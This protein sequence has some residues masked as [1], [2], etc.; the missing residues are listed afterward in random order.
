MSVDGH[1]DHADLPDTP[2]EH[3][4]IEIEGDLL[5]TGD[6]DGER[7][8]VAAEYVRRY[9]TEILDRADLTPLVSAL[10]NSGP[11][12]LLCVERGP[13]ACRRSLIALRLTE[14]HRVTIEHLRQS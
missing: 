13:E 1:C 3:D 11:A 2:S 5:T 9:T 8:E 10:S 12:A 7:D 14:Q 4:F 6:P